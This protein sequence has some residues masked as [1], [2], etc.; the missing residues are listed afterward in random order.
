MPLPSADTVPLYGLA[1]RMT[2]EQ[3]VYADSTFDNRLTFVNAPSGT[4]KTTIAVACAKFRWE[5]SKENK[6]RNK[7]RRFLYYIYSPVEEDKMGFRPGNTREKGEDYLQPLKDALLEVG[8]DPAQAIWHPSDDDSILRDC[9]WV[10]AIPHVFARGMN[11]KD[12]DVI[13]AETQNWTRGEM[14]KVL[15]RIH[16]SC[17]VVAEGHDGQCDLPES[18]TS[19][20]VPYLEYM[21]QFEYVNVVKLTKNFRGQLAQD[22]DKFTW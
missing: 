22:A 2:D 14:K 15:T 13:L 17:T 8:E 20:F 18:S 9:S 12:A 16:D 3:R 21:A 19:G 11:I 10:I 7:P 1:K 4:G 5:Q 6:E